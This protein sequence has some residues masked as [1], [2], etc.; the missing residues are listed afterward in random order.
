MATFGTT[1]KRIYGEGL[2]KY[3]FKKI[4][5]RQP[6][7]VRM[8]G[9]EIIHV[10]TY[11]PVNAHN[12]S[13]KEYEIYGG[14]ATVYRANIDL[15]KTPRDNAVWLRELYRFYRKCNDGSEKKRYQEIGLFSYE[16]DNEQ[17]MAKSIEYSL[18]MTEKYVIPRLD[19][20]TN[21]KEGVDFFEEENTSLLAI[22]RKFGRGQ[23]GYDYNECL[24]NI[25]VYTQD[26]YISYIKN[27]YEECNNRILNEMR[28][29]LNGFTMEQYQ[30][31]KEDRWKGMEEEI[32]VFTEISSSPEK[33]REVMEELERRK[34]HN[35][36]VLKKYGVNTN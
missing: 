33:Y 3:G 25:L 18:E 35:L 34:E 22:D 31:D 19:K 27:L 4:K 11:R 16:K 36:E 29:G 13:H 32:E 28:T 7:F 6:Y 21:V 2:K 14:I 8:I 24:L 10:I 9:D 26:E 1:F 17:A 30:Y 12:F 23:N 5:G 20:I 15:D